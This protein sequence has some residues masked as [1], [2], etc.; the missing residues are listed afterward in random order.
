MEC[1]FTLLCVYVGWTR[2]GAYRRRAHSTLRCWLLVVEMCAAPRKSPD[3]HP[4]E[5]I[6]FPPS[7]THLESIEM[8]RRPIAASAVNSRR[9]PPRIARDR[10]C[11][12]SIRGFRSRALFVP[13]LS[14]VLFSRDLF[15]IGNRMAAEVIL[16]LDLSRY[17]VSTLN[18]NFLDPWCMYTLGFQVKNWH[19]LSSFTVCYKLFHKSLEPKSIRVQFLHNKIVSKQFKYLNI[20]KYYF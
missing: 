20:I 1:P 15:C 18:P 5:R 19:F 4:T 17:K 10:A 6:F 8:A 12:N 13:G 14:Q 16:S 3:Y 9:W 11:P 7:I 2:P